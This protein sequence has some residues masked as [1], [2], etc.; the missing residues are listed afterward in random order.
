LIGEDSEGDNVAKPS[1]GPSRAAGPSDALKPVQARSTHSWR[2]P[3]LSTKE[4]AASYDE[5]QQTIHHRDI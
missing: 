4:V 5:P 3:V 2:A 1:E